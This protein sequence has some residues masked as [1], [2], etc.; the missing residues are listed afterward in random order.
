MT[1]ILGISAF[2]HDS[3]ACLV[4]DGEII[5]AAQEERFTRIKHDYNFPIHA[6]R[7]CLKEAGIT[8]EQLDYVGFLRQTAPE[9]RS[10]ARNVS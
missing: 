2:Y 4:V 6:A 3:A 10:A 1:A 8:A 7:Y 5:A 9:I